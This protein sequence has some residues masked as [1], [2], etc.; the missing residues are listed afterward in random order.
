MAQDFSMTDSRP[1]LVTQWGQSS[2]PCARHPSFLRLLMEMLTHHWTPGGTLH[3]PPQGPA[4]V[5]RGAGDGWGPLPAPQPHSMGSWGVMS[6]ESPVTSGRESLPSASIRN[7][8]P[9]T[10][11]GP[12]LSYLL[13]RADITRFTC[14]VFL[15]VDPSRTG[16]TLLQ[17]A[18]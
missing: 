12:D 6:C 15:D 2:L 18:S 4:P 11:S 5:Q 16:D 14:P 1:V 9:A 13:T 10:P 8:L 3:H 17:A 7:G